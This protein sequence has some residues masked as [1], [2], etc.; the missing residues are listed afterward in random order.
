MWSILL[1]LEVCRIYFDGVLQP[2]D[3][4]CSK[5]ENRHFA[6]DIPFMTATR[7]E[8]VIEFAGKLTTARPPARK[9]SNMRRRL[10]ISSRC[11]RERSA[12]AL[13]PCLHLS[14]L[15]SEACRTH[16]PLLIEFCIKA[17]FTT[18]EIF[19]YPAARWLIISKHFK[20]VP[21]FSNNP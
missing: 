1:W 14:N 16:F 21:A 5:P 3:S 7:G 13:K 12:S 15:R 6:A 17:N 2:A 11:N 9:L 10:C 8:S 19:N 4:C 20:L 18:C